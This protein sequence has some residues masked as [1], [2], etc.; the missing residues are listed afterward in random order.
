M[1]WL[2]VCNRV[3]KV[4]SAPLRKV[5]GVRADQKDKGGGMMSGKLEVLYNTG[6]GNVVYI[7]RTSPQITNVGQQSQWYTPDPQVSV[8][9]DELAGLIE[10]LENVKPGII[11]QLREDAEKK[12]REA[13]LLEESLAITTVTS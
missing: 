13:K 3:S 6:Y 5:Q 10:Q 4:V 9:F 11:K 2:E 12:M 7:R 8:S 1:C